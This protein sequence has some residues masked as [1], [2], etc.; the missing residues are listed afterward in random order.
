M[1]SASRLIVFLHNLAASTRLK[2]WCLL[3]GKPLPFLDALTLVRLAHTCSR[4]REAVQLRPEALACLF[5]D[6]WLRR[7]ERR[8]CSKPVPLSKLKSI[9]SKYTRLN[10]CFARHVHRLDFEPMPF[11]TSNL[12]PPN[13]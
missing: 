2:P 12:Q 1:T 9:V 5:E 6:E 4:G 13:R 10:A 11:N 8:S 7:L 3:E